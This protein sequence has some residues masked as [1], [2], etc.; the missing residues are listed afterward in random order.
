MS[1]P[2]VVSREQ[3]LEARVRLLAEEK[4]MTRR[5]AALN[6][7]RRQLPM[8]KVEK[9]Y[10]FEGPD[11]KAT[12]AD[13]FG[14]ASQ[15]IVQHV[16]FGPDWESVCSGCTAAIDEL[17][18]GVLRHVRSRDTTVVLVSRAPLAKLAAALA[19]KG[20]TVPW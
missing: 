5:L 15:L 6:T 19:S 11:G 8:V 17:S 14:G 3:W 9:E 10:L 20:W 2:K 18:E 4:E 16:M 1:L 13:L 12:L 7:L